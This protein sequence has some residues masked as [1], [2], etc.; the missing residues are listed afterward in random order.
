MNGDEKK[1]DSTKQPYRPTGMK[2]F[3]V[4]EKYKAGDQLLS[5]DY[6]TGSLLDVTAAAE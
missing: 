4:A 2:N 5:D 6:G 3:E 1:K